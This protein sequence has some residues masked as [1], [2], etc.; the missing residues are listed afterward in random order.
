MQNRFGVK[1]FLFLVVLLATLGSVWLSMVQKTRME[2]AQG[3]LK[4][5]LADIEQ[6]VAQLGR[7]LER[8]LEQLPLAA[9]DAAGRRA[10]TVAPDADAWA[11]PGVAVERWSAPMPATDPESV[12]GFTVGGEFTE[13]FEAQPAKLTPFVA[14]DVYSTR[15]LDRVCESLGRF[16]PKTLRMVGSLADAWQID[17]DGLW[18]R[19]HLHPRARFS[20]G[21]PVTAEDVRWTMV[22]FIANP[23]IEAE[24]YRSTQ[25]NL[26]D[27]KV[28]DDRTVEF[29]FKEP[30]FTN[31]LIAFGTAVLPKHYFSKFEPGQINQATGLLMGSGQFR[32]ER[33]PSGPDQLET[34]WTPGQDVVLVRNEQ[35]WG[36]KP[37]L[38][39]MRFKTIKD[40]LG[41]LVAY[42]NGEGSMMLPTSPQFNTV[43]RDEPG[44]EE[45]SYALKW[46]NMRCG[47]SFIAWQC[48]PRNGK[49][50]PFADKRVRRAMTMLLDRERMI[51]DIWD[52]IGTV[53]KGPV[54]PESA[55]SDPELKPLPFDP[56]AA[57]A[58][59][60]EAG[61]QDRNGDGILEDEKGDTFTFEYTYATGGE[62]SE[63]IARFVKD[64]FAKAGIVMKTRPVDWSRYQEILKLR[65]FDAITLAWGSSAPES[66]PRQIWH[67]E[68]VKEGGDNFTQWKSARAD[69][70]I[71][72][73]RRTMDEAE[74]MAVWRQFEACVAE[75]QPY[76]FVRVAPWLRFVKRE[77]GNVN[78]YKTGL[79]PEEFFRMGTPVAPSPAN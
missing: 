69:E 41:R 75:D 34:Q 76:T 44:F 26:K 43:L 30:L 18:I 62:I 3:E 12:P 59:L 70:L 15:V 79:Q 24:R 36:E 7:K 32:L 14:G 6:Q 10:A 72:K 61:W 16:D 58:L 67:S 52:G 42:R 21:Q 31:T 8:G 53:S 71:E 23:L 28:I 54:N 2:L 65:D 1:D 60:A 46:T 78:T 47:Y 77:F 49:P 9:A 73:G 56:D 63:R 39:R 4:S 51:Q 11:R 48:G 37:A 5:K 45:T 13:L 22:D 74:R 33:L 35:Y 27:V 20:D 55:G 57:K 66:D 17:P 68:S 64:S 25:D 50:T 38:D 29:T 19:A 40:D